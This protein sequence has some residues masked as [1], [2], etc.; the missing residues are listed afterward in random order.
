[1]ASINGHL[2]ALLPLLILGAAW[3]G[4][5]VIERFIGERFRDLVRMARFL[6]IPCYGVTWGLESVLGLHREDALF[7]VAQTV[8]GF[9]LVWCL[10]S[11]LQVV[12]LSMAVASD[13]RTRIPRLLIDIV[14]IVFISIG[15]VM[16]FSGVWHKDLSALLATFGVGSLVLGLALQDTLGNLFAGLALVFE[17]PV[18]VGDWIQLG[19]TVGKVTQI[20]WRSVRIVTRELN[21]VTIPN[22]AISKD[23]IINFSAPSRVHGLKVTFGFS[24]DAGILHSPEPEVRTIEFGAYAVQYELRFFINDYNEYVSVRNELMTRVWY[25][26]RRHSI[27]IPYPITTLYKTEVPYLSDDSESG[28]RLINLIRS[29]ELFQDLSDAEAESLAGEVEV[30]R[31]ARGESLVREGETGDCFFILSEGTCAVQLSSR[32][33]GSIG[34]ATLTKGAVVGEMA[35]LSGTPRSATVVASSDVIAARFSR[36]ALSHL[37][38]RREDIAKSF[39]HYAA[40]HAKELEEA[41]SEDARITRSASGSID[42]RALGERIKRFFGIG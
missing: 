14:R 36:V 21:E 34:V 42:E 28:S 11:L 37:L 38:A 4:C 3:I 41:R 1:M 10:T 15:A 5:W 8:F 35:L 32:Q 31:F 39:A 13:V 22:S 27:A 30:L 17:R 12:V 29:T 16:V 9:S 6:V 25:A 2:H 26:A 33:G 23:R 20:N 40:E 7:K 24:Y 19:D 18:S